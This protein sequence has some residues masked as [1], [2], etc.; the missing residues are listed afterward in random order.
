MYAQLSKASF[1]LIQIFIDNDLKLPLLGNKLG[2]Y[3]TCGQSYTTKR[4]LKAVFII[5]SHYNFNILLKVHDFIYGSLGQHSSYENKNN[6]T[7]LWIT[8]LALITEILHIPD[9]GMAGKVSEKVEILI[10]IRVLYGW[11]VGIV[12]YWQSCHP[13]WG[14]I[15]KPTGIK[16]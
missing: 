3:P 5:I 15:W 8:H 12:L 6:E 7:V 4:L 10:E 11:K 14:A 13:C 1:V 2:Q 9:I 16:Q